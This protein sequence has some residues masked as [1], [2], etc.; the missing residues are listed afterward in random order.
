M[1]EFKGF[2][3]GVNF[4]G[5]LSQRSYEKE[6][7]DSFITESDFENVSKWGIDHLRIP[8]DYNIVETEDDVAVAVTDL[9]S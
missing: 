5:W 1:K 8:V 6:Y 3:H 9:N 4:G 7:L 2:M